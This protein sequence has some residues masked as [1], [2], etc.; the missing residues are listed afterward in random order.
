MGEMKRLKIG[1][2]EVG[3]NRHMV[4]SFARCFNYIFFVSSAR[5]PQNNSF[6]GRKNTSG[7]IKTGN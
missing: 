3:E 2:G 4:K 7:I 1:K 6:L 5:K